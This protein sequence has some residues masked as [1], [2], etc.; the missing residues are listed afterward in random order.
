M[1]AT[2]RSTHRSILPDTIARAV[3]NK[4][5][6]L[7][8]VP[9]FSPLFPPSPFFFSFPLFFPLFHPC[10]DRNAT[11]DK[12]HKAERFDRGREFWQTGT[13]CVSFRGYLR[14]PDFANPAFVRPLYRVNWR[15][16][17][18]PPLPP[19]RVV[20][21]RKR[22]ACTLPR[23][24]KIVVAC[25]KGEQESTAVESVWGRFG[26]KWYGFRRSQSITREGEGWDSIQ[27]FRTIGN[28][29]SAGIEGWFMNRM[30]TVSDR[31]R[32]FTTCAAEIVFVVLSRFN[33]FI[34]IDIH[35][36]V[37]YL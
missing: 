26:S 36:R 35:R 18:P 9:I 3:P 5:G 19:E 2:T 32:P 33:R 8:I 23:S 16:S 15:L 29:R 10:S 25:W 1:H 11:R 20:Q 34:S 21:R 31:E 4:S 17:P 28:I 13:P 30:T 6:R 12:P 22:R 7:R 24:Q 37:Q 14:P 27:F